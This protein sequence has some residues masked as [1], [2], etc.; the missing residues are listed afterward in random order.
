ML[1]GAR[2]CGGSDEPSIVADMGTPAADAGSE[3][4]DM[5]ASPDDLGAPPVDMGSVVVDMSS[6]VDATVA[7]DG[8]IEP[9]PSEDFVVTSIGDTDTD[10]NVVVHVGP[11]NLVRISHYGEAGLVYFTSETASGSWE[12]IT[13]DEAPELGFG[14]NYR[15]A[16]A[17][18][19]A[20]RTHVVYRASPGNSCRSGAATEKFDSEIRYSVVSA[21]VA[22]TPALLETVQATHDDDDAYRE[23]SPAIAIDASGTVHVVYRAS[24]DD[25]ASLRYVTIT[26]GSASAPATIPD[27]ATGR[28]PLDDTFTRGSQMAAAYGGLVAGVATDGTLN[29][30]GQATST[31]GAVVLRRTL[32]GWQAPISLSTS[33]YIVS[34]DVA[35]DGTLVVATLNLETGVTTLRTVSATGEIGAPVE[36]PTREECE[37][38][39]LAL[40]AAGAPSVVEKCRAGE[41]RFVVFHSL[42]T[43]GWLPE[44]RVDF[45]DGVMVQGLTPSLAF[46][47]AGRPV[48][49]FQAWG[50]SALYVARLGETP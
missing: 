9:T 24:T 33:D 25:V 5:S 49:A 10:D 19:A 38:N 15:T 29:V 47:N 45:P 16:S 17:I 13:L 39:Q 12:T 35:A 2:D 20:G 3:T 14:C 6:P 50:A 34:G 48:L 31:R 32:S 42:A 44:T 36:V 7:P 41:D 11:D 4:F 21:G 27:S 46:D 8:H 30:L 37:V 23:T 26:E 28:G 40:D 43:V 22:S 18:D 1:G